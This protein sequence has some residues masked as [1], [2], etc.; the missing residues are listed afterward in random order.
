[1]ENQNLGNEVF[2]QEETQLVSF[3]PKTG[4]PIAYDPTEQQYPDGA[5]EIMLAGECDR[6]RGGLC[7]CP[8]DPAPAIQYTT[9]A[10]PAQGRFPGRP[11]ETHTA[12]IGCWAASNTRFYIVNNYKF[13]SGQSLKPVA[14][15]AT[16]KCTNR[17]GNGISIPDAIEL[18]KLHFKKE[19]AKPVLEL[20]NVSTGDILRLNKAMAERELESYFGARHRRLKQLAAAVAQYDESSDEDETA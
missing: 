17:N 4:D 20:V 9:K 6:G 8:K 11:A 16:E 12:H 10:R 3:T 7:P 1:M 2:G 18:V 15:Y 14:K 5:V 19:F 13:V